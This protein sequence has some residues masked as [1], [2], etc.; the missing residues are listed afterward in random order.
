MKNIFLIFLFLILNSV[1]TFANESFIARVQADFTELNSPRAGIEVEIQ[2]LTPLQVAEIIAQKLGG[3]VSQHDKRLEIESDDPNYIFKFKIKNTILGTMQVH[4][5]DNSTSTN[6]TLVNTA[7]ELVTPPLN[8]EQLQIF[9][10]FLDEF[11]NSGALGTEGQRPISTQLTI[12]FFHNNPDQTVSR[13]VHFLRLY[14]SPDISP[15]I[16]NFFNTPD[17]RKT[18]IGSLSIGLMNKINS[19]DYKPTAEEFFFDVLYRQVLELNGY[20]KAWSMNEEDARE[21]ILKIAS[22]KNGLES[23]LKAVKW[24][25]IKISSLLIYLFPED[26]IS[27]FLYQTGW[28]K[29]YPAIEFREGNTDFLV[30]EKYLFLSSLIQHTFKEVAIYEQHPEIISK[31]LDPQTFMKLMSETPEDENTPWVVRLVTHNLS[32]PNSNAE[33]KEILRLNQKKGASAIFL[34]PQTLSKSI[35]S[36]ANL[37]GSTLLPQSETQI[38]RPITLPGES[39]VYHSLPSYAR[40][41]VGKYNPALINQHLVAA[42]ESKDM[43]YKFWQKFKPNVIPKTFRLSSLIKPETSLADTL[44]ILEAEFPRGW[45]LKGTHDSATEQKLITNRSD[46]FAAL[47]EYNENFESFQAKR[48]EIFSKYGSLSPDLILGNLTDL[49]GF[50]GW[51]I[52]RFLNRPETAIVQELVEI[53]TEYRVE[54]ALGQVLSQGSTVPRYN[55]KIPLPLQQPVDQA[56][57]LRVEAFAQSLLDALP[58]QL[59]VTPFALDVAV[60]TNGQIILIESNPGPNSGFLAEDDPGVKALNLELAKWPERLNKGIVNEGLSLQDQQNLILEL[61]H[62]LKIE[63]DNLKS[64]KTDSTQMCMEYLKAI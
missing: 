27:K 21:E 10:K 30:L 34:N 61:Q 47:K 32:H 44:K 41:L 11:K 51:R 26:P 53:Q 4:T 7:S 46:L 64:N 14:F 28:I 20:P 63:S 39:V 50:F 2:G 48:Q 37:A 42:I 45:I 58:A 5:D 43:E 57:V 55:Y 3:K 25:D 38:Q 56:E 52:K 6:I 23:F 12:D 59:K 8:F 36:K 13:L 22:Q 40:S 31:G 33:L 9:Q 29:S 1:S 35:S 62:D 60:L 17:I 49:P 15:K 19:V 16:K 24:N 54:L 18:Y